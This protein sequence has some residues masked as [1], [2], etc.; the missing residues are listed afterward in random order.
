M[1]TNKQISGVRASLISSGSIK[2][3]SYSDRRYYFADFTGKPAR[4]ATES[5]N[6][7]IQARRATFNHASPT[8]AVTKGDNAA[9]KP[10]T[11][12][13]HDTITEAIGRVSDYIP[14][15]SALVT[16]LCANST[17]VDPNAWCGEWHPLGELESLGF[18]GQVILDFFN[19]VCGSSVVT[20]FAMF[21]AVQLGFVTKQSVVDWARTGISDF[22]VAFLESEV[23]SLLIVFGQ[24]GEPDPTQ[25]L[26]DTGLSKDVLLKARITRLLG[27]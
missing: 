26:L 5:R 12:N 22:D 9:P 2:E 20:C 4:T 1:K 10:V 11:K 13:G 24:G 19:T 27:G 25:R 23:K 16:Q 18:K 17:T 15:V 21:R 7:A 6:A 14:A 3:M 8:V